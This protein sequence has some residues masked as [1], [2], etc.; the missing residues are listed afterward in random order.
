MGTNTSL[1]F[2]RPALAQTSQEKCSGSC[3]L[4]TRE[5]LEKPRTG[6]VVSFSKFIWNGNI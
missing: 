5:V 6:E 1:F 2:K 3:F 4:W